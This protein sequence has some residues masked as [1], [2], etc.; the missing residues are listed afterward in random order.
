MDTPRERAAIYANATRV[1]VIFLDCFCNGRRRRR[2][3]RRLTP[4]TFL[5][6]SNGERSLF[7]TAIR[8]SSRSIIRS[9][10]MPAAD[11]TRYVPFS[12]L[13]L[14]TSMKEG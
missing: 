6:A 10:A 1:N 12:R 4:A 13:R 2:R 3:R 8:G 14:D 11:F 5:S 7:R 9:G